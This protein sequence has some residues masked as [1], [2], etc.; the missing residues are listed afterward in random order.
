M[1][2]FYD[3]AFQNN[4]ESRQSY[5]RKHNPDLNEDEINGIVDQLD[6]EN[7]QEATGNS[8]LDRL[9]NIGG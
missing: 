7:P 4:L 5:L 9:E 8:L 3:W 6:Q 1:I 2:K